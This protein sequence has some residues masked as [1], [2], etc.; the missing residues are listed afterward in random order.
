VVVAVAGGGSSSSI[1]SSDNNNDSY[2][3]S[4]MEVE[5]NNLAKTKIYK[6]PSVNDFKNQNPLVTCII[7]KINFAYFSHHLNLGIRIIQ[8][9]NTLT[10]WS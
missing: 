7:S 4:H 2:T 9:Q 10:V 8:A 5:Y 1:S 6:L 3:P